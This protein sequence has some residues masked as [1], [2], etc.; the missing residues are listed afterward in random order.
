[1]PTTKAP[2][3]MIRLRLTTEHENTLHAIRDRERISS[4][5]NTLDA[6]LR[7]WNMLTP[8]QRYDAMQR[9]IP[10]DYGA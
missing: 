5:D 6:V 1:M 4:L 9:Q 7:G 10:A 2:H 8:E 3:R